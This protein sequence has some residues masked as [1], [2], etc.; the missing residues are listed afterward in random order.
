M[1]YTIKNG[2]IIQ[3]YAKLCEIMQNYAKLCKIMQNYAKLCEIMQNYAK[4]W[5]LN[6]N[7]LKKDRPYKKIHISVDFVLYN[8]KR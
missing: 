8:A 4:L 7:N 1:H 6:Y 3:N 2:Q 5:V